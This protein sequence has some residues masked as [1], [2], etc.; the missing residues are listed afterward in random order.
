MTKI[1]FV[2]A[3]TLAKGIDDF[4]KLA[5]LVKDAEFYWFTYYVSKDV[6]T[7]YK[8]IKFIV[9]LS[10]Q[11]LKKTISKDMDIF[12]CCSGF[13]GF[14]LPLAE[15]MI[16]KKPVITYPLSEIKQEF[17][18]NVEYVNGV[19][20]FRKRLVSI[21]GKKDYKKDLTK[22]KKFVEMNFSPEKVS[23]RL[24]NNLNITLAQN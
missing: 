6:L 18:N 14:C 11:K 12:I 8:N 4:N 21:I 1:Y 3:A 13:E 15:A 24:L 9:G 16:L 10:D 2:G 20:Q 23:G 17:L 19:E 22:A 7:K 5:G